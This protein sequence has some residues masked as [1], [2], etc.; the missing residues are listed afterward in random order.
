G[1]TSVT[2]P[3][4]ASGPGPPACKLA[5][6]PPTRRASEETHENAPIRAADARAVRQR[7]RC[8]ASPHR[9]RGVLRRGA[10][11]RRADLARRP[12]SL[13]RQAL[14]GSAQ[15]LGQEDHRTVLRR[16]AGERRDSPADS[17]LLLEPRWPVPAVR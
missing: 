11:R 1:A 7:P 5:R 17:R 10:D 14:P 2:V 12:L 3:W 15:H 8:P 6:A 9:P 4:S 13:L 16:E